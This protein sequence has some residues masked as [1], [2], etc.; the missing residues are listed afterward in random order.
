MSDQ[1]PQHSLTA[2][3]QSHLT[4]RQFV[5]LGVSASASALWLA[6]CGPAP[7]TPT[8]APTQ[9]SGSIKPPALKK[10]GVFK[11]AIIG[12]PPAIA[13]A[14]FTTATVTSNVAMQFF[15]GLFTRDAKFSPKPV[16]VD[17]YNIAPD[18]KTYEFKLRKSI[19]FHNGKPLEAA[20]VA[21]SLERWGALT[22]RGQT[23]FKRLDKIETPDAQTVKINF[24]DPTG[25]L[26]DYLALPEAFILPAEIAKAAGKDALKKDQFVGTGPFKFTEYIADRFIRLT[27]YDGY[28]PRDENPDG[29]SGKREPYFD[30]IQFIPVPDSSVRANG[31]ITGEYHYADTLPPDQYDVL[32]GSNGVVTI[33]VKPYYWYCPH[34][35]KKKGLFTN[36]KMRH[37]VAACI[38][39]EEAMIAGFGNK[40]FIRVDGGIDAPETAW[41]STAGFENFNK[42][43]LN[44]AKQLLKDA[45]YNGETIRW[46]ATKEYDYNYKMAEYS[47]QK[48]EAAGMKVELVVSD[49]ATLVKNRANPDVYEIF[50]TGHA[51]Y[52]H[53]A[54]HPFMAESW[55][56]FWSSPARDAVL[57]KIIAEPDLAKQKPLYDEL[58]AVVYKEMPFVKCGDNFLLRAMR[59]DVV[60]YQ[61]IPDYYFWNVGFA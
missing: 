52:V 9:V 12:E 33:V 15:E 5:K 39:A 7:A 2:P 17:Q 47:K 27:R 18:G 61:N 46:L 60:N 31:I 44:R 51:S 57:N 24:K 21:A 1:N 3:A 14:M 37:A 25:I 35:N 23:I 30:E 40:D 10:G 13:D 41:Y 22:G 28:A 54:T 11:V 59:K 49:W 58:Q 53:P 19:K 48:M 55:P 42:P 45:G 56:G 36:E 8:T 43:D 32:K 16:L 20:D 6:A 4:R 26:L 34:F 29:A 38:N 50:L